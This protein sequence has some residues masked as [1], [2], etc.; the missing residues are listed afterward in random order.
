MLQDLQQS[1]TQLGAEFISPLTVL[2][3]KQLACRAYLADW[4]GVFN[5]GHKAS[6]T[7]GSSF[8]EPDAMGLNMLRF[9][10]WLRHDRM[11]TMGIVTGELNPASF[12]LALR[13]HYDFV[14]FRVNHKTMALDWLNRERGMAD[15]HIGFMMDDVLDLSIASR[16]NLKLLVNRRGSPLFK[17]L[18]RHREYADYI[19]GMDGANHAV[20]E[21]CELLIGLNG[22]FSETMER[23]VKFIG[24]YSKFLSQRNDIQTRFLTAGPN[25]MEELSLQ[26][27][28]QL[29]SLG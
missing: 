24:E 1:F 9:S 2:S 3:R 29:V 25:G 14:F 27:V 21:I 10:S 16:V 22:N 12:S 4:D 13:D 8:S 17:E 23:R 11:P 19:S 20:R 6:T 28:Q 26:Q 15:H 5:N 18:I 7:L